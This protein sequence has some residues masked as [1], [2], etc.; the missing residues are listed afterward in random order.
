M[1]VEEDGIGMRD[2]A[3]IYWEEN[4]WAQN[5]INGQIRHLKD[6][7]VIIFYTWLGQKL[8]RF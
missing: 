7:S 2:G 4:V 8:E 3:R 5:Q 1:L 6:E